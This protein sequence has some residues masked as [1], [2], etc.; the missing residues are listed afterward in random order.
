[1]APYGQTTVKGAENVD[2]DFIAYMAGLK[3]GETYDPKDLDD[4]RE[5]LVGLDVFNSVTITE[6]ESLNGD[7][8]LPMMIE[9]SERKHRYFG[10]GA[11]YSSTEGG[12]IEGY[13]GHR[14]LFGHAEKLRIHGSISRLGETTDFGKLNYNA[15]VMFQKPGVLGPASKFVSSIDAISEHTDAY[16]RFSVDARAG[17]T[18]DLDRKQTVSGEVRIEW[19]RI[20]NDPLMTTASTDRHLLV[21]IPL[22]YV[23]DGRDNRLNPTKG[24]RVL[25]HVE[26]T[27]DLFTGA[28]FVKLNGE[29]SAYQS[30]DEEDKFVLAG[31]VAAGS[32]LGAPLAAIPADRRFY[33]GG[34]GSVRG[35][36]YQGVGPRDP[37]TG[38]P[39]GGR[40]FA[41][42]SL[43]MRIAVTD[44]LGIVPFVDAGTVSTDSVPDFSDIRVGAGLGL[45]Y[46]TGFGPL[47]IDVGVPL[48]RRPGEPTFGIYAGIGQAF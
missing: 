27:Y 42:A 6:G 11:T 21:S 23:Y 33:S 10:V 17:I 31:R 22:E 30:F 34:G 43:E 18:R 37:A 19:S 46:L 5:R 26:P 32:I 38:K 8:S 24:F 2:S 45:R 39:L 12:G 47:R 15:G 40:S 1:M 7:G 20:T 25:A 13:W 44:K 36:A 29:A 16:D 9:V 28:T 4:A 41:E 48:N 3:P 14:N 35:Y